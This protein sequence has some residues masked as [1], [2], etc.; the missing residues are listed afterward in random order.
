MPNFPMPKARG[1]Y[2]NIRLSVGSISED[3]DIREKKPD[4]LIS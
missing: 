1:V 2:Q 4:T 3:Q